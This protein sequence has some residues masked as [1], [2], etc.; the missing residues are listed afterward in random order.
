MNQDLI[1][2]HNEVV[3]EQDHTIH[4]GDFTLRNKKFAQSIIKQLNGT[5]TFLLGS[6]DYWLQKN[7]LQIWEKRVEK[8]YIIAC[9][10]AMHTWPRSH[11]GS[12]HI[13]G[14]SH[15]NLKLPGKRYDVGVDNNQYYPISFEDLAVIMT[16]VEK[17]I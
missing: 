1:Q 8:E 6:H 4:L 10:Y 7:S 12:W 13:F 16:A 17:N 3:T 9:H 15:G 5:H 14:H 2:K 11:Y